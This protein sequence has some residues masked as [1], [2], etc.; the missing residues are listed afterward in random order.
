MQVVARAL[1]ARAQCR[2]VDLRVASR[3]LVRVRAQPRRLE[4]HPASIRRES[5]PPM[6]R[7]ISSATAQTPTQG[8]SR[9]RPLVL[10]VVYF[11]PA[12][13]T[14]TRCPVARESFT[15]AA[16][17][18][19]PHHSD[20][21]F[22]WWSSESA[23]PACVIGNERKERKIFQ[24][25]YTR[26]SYAERKGRAVLKCTFCPYDA[27][28]FNSGRLKGSPRFSI[29]ILPAVPGHQVIVATRLSVVRSS[30]LL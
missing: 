9:R 13:Y 4:R 15:R 7:V 3:T 23:T 11:T 20:H 27:G 2:G 6:T 21:E 10:P 17:T 14:P 8:A 29:L 22:Q 26:P 5:R 18:A 12:R 1:R 30:R 19:L 28:I 16:C 25:Y 24:L